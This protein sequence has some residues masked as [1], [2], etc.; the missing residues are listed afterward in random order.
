MVCLS[1]VGCYNFKPPMEAEAI[2]LQRKLCKVANE[3][4]KTPKSGKKKSK[5]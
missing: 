1:F 4:F 2:K 3:V 5:D